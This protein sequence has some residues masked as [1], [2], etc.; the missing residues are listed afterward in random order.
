MLKNIEMKAIELNQD[1]EAVKRE[2]KRVASVKCRLLKQKGRPDYE[3]AMENV[4]KEE[5]LLKEVRTYL[6]GTKKTVTTFGQEDVDQLTYDETVKALRSIQSKKS[7]TRWLTTVEGDNDEF[8]SACKV[9]D[10]LKEHMK[11]VKPIEDNTIRKSDVQNVIDTIEAT[12]KIS[13]EKIL[14]ML[15]ALV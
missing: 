2:L 10:M 9:E 8:R 7:L 6:T 1:M 5:Q 12:G 13:T 4:L 3:E 11:S 15:K 14:E